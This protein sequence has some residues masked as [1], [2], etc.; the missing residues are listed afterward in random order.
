M[1]ADFTSAT[2]VLLG[3]FKPD[4]FLPEVLSS[5]RVISKSEAKV[6]KFRA[7]LPDAAVHLELSWG[8]LLVTKDRVQV[9]TTEAPYVRICDF[10][11]KALHDMETESAV[12]AF[13]INL[14]SHFNLGSINARDNLGRRIA[15]PEAWGNWGSEILK[16]MQSKSPLRGGMMHLQMRM[17][18][19]EDKV[20]GWMDVFAGPSERIPNNTGVF[21]RTNH[22]HQSPKQEASGA[23]KTQSAP[24]RTN[25]L[26]L[27]DSL[28][29]RFDASIDRAVNIFNGVLQ[30]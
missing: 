13:G 25:P 9:S 8:E 16:S 26:T 11:I 2:I 20:A 28:A 17:P 27:L 6:A 15:P 30:T 12:S 10:V 18:F 21:F 23:E 14:E 7:L 19:V 5:A 29:E 4:V 1:Q 22:H 24:T 3:K